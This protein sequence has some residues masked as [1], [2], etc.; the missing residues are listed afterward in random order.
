MG[1]STAHN[2]SFSQSVASQAVHHWAQASTAAAFSPK[3]VPI[4]LPH[5][6]ATGGLPGLAP[7]A[8]S[9]VEDAAVTASAAKAS[10]A[11]SKVQPSTAK[12]SGAAP[13]AQPPAAFHDYVHLMSPDD[14]GN[15]AKG[16]CGYDSSSHSSDNISDLVPVIMSPT[17]FLRLCPPV[18]DDKMRGDICVSADAALAFQTRGIAAPVLHV[19]A[20]EESTGDESVFRV[21]SHEGRHRVKWIQNS[22]YNMLV[23]YIHCRTPTADPHCAAVPLAASTATPA[24]PSDLPAG[25]ASV[26]ILGTMYEVSF[27]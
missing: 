10:R 21:T 26:L 4:P 8:P 5:G 3:A 20:Q 22:G 12:A 9:S 15:A 7:Q 19:E 25:R 14:I 23:V 6:M 1:A 17:D 2:S 13:K 11:A 18:A 27:A 16:P 24:V